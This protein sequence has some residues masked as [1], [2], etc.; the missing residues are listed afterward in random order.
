MK[1]PTRGGWRGVA[2]SGP[3]YGMIEHG[4]ARRKKTIVQTTRKHRH[5]TFPRA[6]LLHDPRPE[7]KL[8]VVKAAK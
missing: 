7:G 8:P 1:N 5:K 4:T 6:E 2:A 3:E